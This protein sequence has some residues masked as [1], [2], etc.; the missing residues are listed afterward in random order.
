MH[1]ILL[2][3]GPFTFYTY[4]L[5]VALAFAAG[6]GAAVNLG[7][8]AAY[9]PRE[10]ADM[11]LILALSGFMGSRLMHVLLHTSDY[12]L[13]P[14]AVFK[15]WQGGFVFSGGI[16][17]AFLALAWY[18]RRHGTSLLRAGDLWAP[19]VALAQGIGWIGC[20]MAGCGYGRPTAF[21]WGVV[22]T[23]PQCLAP[24]HVPLHPTQIYASLSAFMIFGLLFAFSR[25]K[26]F[27]GQILLWF[28]ILNSA[29]RFLIEPFRG[30]N[31]GLIFGSSMSMTQ[32]TALLI[33]VSALAALIHI[34]PRGRERSHTLE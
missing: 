22:F 27:Q 15:V 1:P 23:D 21:Q 7:R 14:S 11:G 19:A 16:L 4:G 5:S 18:T 24:L 9:T 26:R 28:L 12:R 30:D 13:E 8:S 33:F 17:G 25:R 29:T 6:L 32:F 20:L 10:I 31:R 3:L 34:R 2:S